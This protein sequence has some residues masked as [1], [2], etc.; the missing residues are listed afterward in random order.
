M[1]LNSDT[2]QIQQTLANYC[3][4]GQDIELP[5]LT[6]NRVHTY[7]RMVFNVALDTLESAFPITKKYIDEDI[8][9][10]MAHQFFTEHSCSSPLLWQMPLE[11]HNF[12]K[13]HQFA[14]KFHLPFLNDLL[15]FEW[16]E[17]E[18]FMMENKSYPV[19]QSEGDVFKNVLEFNPEHKIIKLQYPVHIKDPEQALKEKGDYFLLAYREKDSGKVQFVNLSVLYV[20]TLEHL[21]SKPLT[22]DSL[23]DDILYLFGINDLNLL[24]E[25][26]SDFVLDLKQRGFIIGY[27]I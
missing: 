8:F 16:L 1:L 3:R 18:L 6:P 25:K 26:I 21:L 11:F 12:A 4:D 24:K 22:I 17:I 14:E 2:Y 20:F 19:V 23:L 5:N 15:W 7:R 9:E 27:S 10:A 13:E